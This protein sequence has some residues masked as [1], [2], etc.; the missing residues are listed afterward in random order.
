MMQLSNSPSSS[1]LSWLVIGLTLAALPHFAYQPIWVSLIFLAMMAWRLMAINFSWPLPG[2]Q[3]RSLTLLQLAIAVSAGLLLLNSYGNIIGRDAGTALLVVMLGLK[4][5]EIRT[6]RDFYL[7]SFL[8]YFLVVTNFLYSQSIATAG[9]MFIV[10]IIMTTSL[11]SLNANSLILSQR[12]QLKIATKILLQAIP[13]MLVLF[14]LF[15]RI[16]GPLWGLPQDAHTATTGMDNKMTLGKISQLIQSDDIAFR[17]KFDD[18]RPAPV[19]QYWR[20]PVLWQTDGTTWTELDTRALN[21]QAVINTTGKGYAYTVTMEPHNEKW[22]FALDFPVDLPAE[23]DAIQTYDGKVESIKPI[24]QRVQYKLVSHPQFT[25]NRDNEPYLQQALQLPKD[26]HSRTI[27]LAQKWQQETTT[28]QQLVDRALRHFNQENFFYTL[29]PPVLTGDSIDN[30]LFE[31]RRGFCEHYAA[32]FTVLMRAA[33][34]PARIVT[35]YQGGEF[36][37]VDDYIVVRQHDAHAWTEVWL[38]G[39][40]WTRVDPTAAVSKQRIENG[41]NTIMPMTMR[42]PLFF[43]ANQQLTELW[44][45]FRYN[46]DALNNAW[47][48]AVLAYGPELQK[49]FLAKLGMDNPDWQKMILY[50]IIFF[51]LTLLVIIASFLLNRRKSDPISQFYQLF[52]KKLSRLGIDHPASEGPLALATKACKH[53]PHHQQQIKAISDLYIDLRYGKQTASVKEL[54]KAVH[55]FRPKRL[56]TNK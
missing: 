11:I 22:L 45:R 44:Q 37:P 42:S 52:C 32:S 55:Q 6:I 34:I 29:T 46:W 56:R 43:S 40:G 28:P 10:V 38:A 50:L 27:E 48:R 36:N 12:H 49:R 5:V 21:K 53:S 35:G 31:S 13:L 9:L 7:S 4:V 26:Q 20:G 16:S 54:K 14:V 3:H 39:Q 23:L 15:P 25:F 17:V 30:F 2:K 47:N 19:N 51:N 1:A 18:D 33:G 41:M 8:G 24:K